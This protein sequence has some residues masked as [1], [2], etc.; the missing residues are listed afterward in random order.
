M[1]TN[2]NADVDVD[3]LRA[4]VQELEKEKALLEEELARLRPAEPKVPSGL[5]IGLDGGEN[6]V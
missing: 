6:C 2:Q 5:A 4:K 1:S 3:F